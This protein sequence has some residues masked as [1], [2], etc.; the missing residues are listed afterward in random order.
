MQLTTLLFGTKLFPEKIIEVL[1]YQ[2]PKTESDQPS[3]ITTQIQQ[4]SMY[5]D[6][7]DLPLVHKPKIRSA[8]S[9]VERR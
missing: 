1:P 5:P 4:I 3:V 6:S 8:F 9:I 7:F 2:S